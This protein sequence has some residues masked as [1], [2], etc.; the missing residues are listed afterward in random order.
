M[1]VKHKQNVTQPPPPYTEGSLVKKED[2]KAWD[3]EAVDVRSRP[4]DP[5]AAAVHAN[6]EAAHV[7]EAGWWRRFCPASSQSLW[8]TAS[9]PR[10]RSKSD[11]VSSR[12]MKWKEVLQQFW[13]NFHDK[14]TATAKEQSSQ[15]GFQHGTSGLVQGGPYGDYVQI[16]EDTKGKLKP[17]LQRVPESIYYDAITLEMAMELVKYPKELGVDE[18]K[19]VMIGIGRLGVTFGRRLLDLCPKG[20]T[21]GGADLG[22]GAGLFCETET[23]SSQE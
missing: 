13:P 21:L 7:F 9:R 5:P 12:S 22:D 20:S 4:Q 14:V 10:W 19:P 18:G 15:G 8:T 11:A 16:R 3:G 1:D 17:K 23:R 2:G 6:R